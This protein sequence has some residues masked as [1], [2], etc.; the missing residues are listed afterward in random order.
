MMAKLKNLLNHRERNFFNIL[1][2][3]MSKRAQVF[4]MNKEKLKALRKQ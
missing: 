2:N 3:R 4:L 1:V